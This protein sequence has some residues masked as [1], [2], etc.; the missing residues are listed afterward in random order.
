MNTLKTT[1]P[2]DCQNS[3]EVTLAA[4]ALDLLEGIKVAEHSLPDRVVGINPCKWL[5]SSVAP[6]LLNQS[7]LLAS[8]PVHY[9]K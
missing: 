3:V 1:A 4:T 5:N 7:Y 6:Q 9:I 8:C 2:I